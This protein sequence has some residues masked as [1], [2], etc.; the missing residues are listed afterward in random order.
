MKNKVK[1]KLNR[2]ETNKSFNEFIELIDKK[3]VPKFI[4]DELH[5]ETNKLFGVNIFPVEPIDPNKT[6]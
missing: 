1:N 3:Q 6:Q 5:R 2:K 4:L